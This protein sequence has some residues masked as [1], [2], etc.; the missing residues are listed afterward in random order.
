[1]GIILGKFINL[2]FAL[3]VEIFLIS[4]SIIFI[5]HKKIFLILILLSFL[6]LGCVRFNNSNCLYFSKKNGGCHYVGLTRTIF[7]IKEKLQNVHTQ[8]LPRKH[9]N[10]LISLV[11]GGSS[12]NL[13]FKTKKAFLNLG[14][15]HLLVVSGAQVSIIMSLI[16]LLSKVFHIPKLPFFFMATFFNFSFA[17]MTGAQPSIVRA[18][19]MAQILLISDLFERNYD[20]FSSL[21]LVAFILTLI[22]PNL[23]YSPAFQLSFTA[24]F[25]LLHVAPI[26]SNKLKI[27]L[28]GFLSQLI[29]ISIAPTLMTYPITAYHF[30]RISIISTLS[31]FLA[32]SWIEV[33]VILGFITSLIGQVSLFL[34]QIL[35]NFNGL[36]ISLLLILVNL[37]NKIS[38]STISINKPSIISIIVFYLFG[39]YLLEIIKKGFK[40]NWIKLSIAILISINLILCHKAISYVSSSIANPKSNLLQ[41][42]ILD[43]GQGDSIFIKAPS[44]RNTL[45][46]GGPKTRYFNAG[47]K[48]VCKFLRKSG[49]KRIDVI[50]LSHAHADHV[51]GL[52]YIINNFPVGLIIDPGLPHT[53]YLYK[54]FL[55]TIKKKK[56]PYRR[57]KKG[58]ILDYLDGIKGYILHPSNPLITKTKSDLN[59]N[60]VVLKLNY[61]K[62]S[63]LFL[64]DL[65]FEGEERLFQNSTDLKSDVI[66]IGHHGSKNATS[67]GL[68]NKVDPKIA[69]ISLSKNNRYGYPH[70]EVLKRLSDKNIKILRTDL[71][72]N[73]TIF[74]TGTATYFARK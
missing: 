14:L 16:L 44:G 64:G 5:K 68:L 20:S 4:L 17:I 22:S 61:N 57:A 62:T 59:N 43:V 2:Y 31:N 13:D 71:N 21:A 58:Q 48:V 55:K 60:S 47:K 11:F 70:P 35:N 50:I 7:N 3:L 67:K 41:V 65:E 25:S 19:L 29:A 18:S 45:I 42:T 37:L 56:I 27:Y 51:G 69:I 23:I 54:N 53:S 66:K 40:Q 8:T 33:L 9:A 63:F 26:L 39:F 30:E 12:S 24:T 32:I 72:G 38:W 28:P 10:L 6:L 34:A 46:D 36:I 1:M 15:I 74:S 52:S 73:I 49:I